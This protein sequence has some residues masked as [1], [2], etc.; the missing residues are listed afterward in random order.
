MRE[1]YGGTQ[2]ASVLAWGLPSRCQWRYTDPIG[3]RDWC[4]PRSVVGRLAGK[5]GELRECGH[6]AGTLVNDR[7]R[8]WWQ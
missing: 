1:N 5:D 8:H 6:E 2:R 3:E 4:K 7:W